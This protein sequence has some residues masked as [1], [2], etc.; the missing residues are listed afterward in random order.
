MRHPPGNAWWDF[1]GL[2][3]R[4]D[5]VCGTAVR[6]DLP[7][8]VWTPSMGGGYFRRVELKSLSSSPAAGFS[9]ASL[10]GEQTK[11]HQGEIHASTGRAVESGRRQPRLACFGRL[12]VI[13]SDSFCGETKLKGYVSE[14]GEDSFVIVEG[15]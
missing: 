14:A 7:E 11:E 13:K 3:R 5:R 15:D 9:P 10:L 4:Y 6:S 1:A 8:C 2:P 12:E